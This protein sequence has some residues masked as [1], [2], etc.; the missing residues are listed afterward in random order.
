MLNNYIVVSR[1]NEVHETE[2]NIEPLL[3]E[4]SVIVIYQLL[5]LEVELSV[6]RPSV[7]EIVVQISTLP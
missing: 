5:F 3:I 4:V 2:I 7:I 1:S 6:K